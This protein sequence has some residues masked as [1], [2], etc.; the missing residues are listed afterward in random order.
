MTRNFKYTATAILASVMAAT[1]FGASA[2]DAA[3]PTPA[4][5]Q[6]V[7]PVQQTPTTDPSAAPTTPAQPAVPPVADNAAT[8][9]GTT[10]PKDFIQQAYLANEFGVAAAQV[11]L[12]ISTDA[13]VKTAAQSLLTDGTATRQEMIKAIQGSTADMHFDQAWP[14][15]YKQKLADLQSVAG[16]EF[17]KKYVELQGAELDKATALFSSYASSATDASTK[18]FASATL[19]K[20]QAQAAALDAAAPTGTAGSR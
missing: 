6:A 13:E 11:A 9:A 7:P 15:D 1:A 12:K 17:D 5:S 10:A 4:D 2:Q 18:T 19:P 3:A 8:A 16:P 14:E 20:L